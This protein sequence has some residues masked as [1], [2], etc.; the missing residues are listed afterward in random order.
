MADDLDHILNK[1]ESSDDTNYLNMA[2]HSWIRQGEFTL[3]VKALKRALTNFKKIKNTNEIFGCYINIGC[4]Y[5]LAKDYRH[6]IEY[7]TKALKY[8]L[9]HCDTYCQTLAY[10]NVGGVLSRSG[11]NVKKGI[12][13]LKHAEKLAIELQDHH[14]HFVISKELGYSYGCIGQNALATDYYKEALC[15]SEEFGSNYRLD[16]LLEFGRF[17][18]NSNNSSNAL[19]CYKEALE[20]SSAANDTKSVSLCYMNIGDLHSAQGAFE[21]ATANY[22][23]AKVIAQKIHD[24]ELIDNCMGRLMMMQAFANKD[25]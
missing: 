18:Q 23:R 2:A 5:Q 20:L 10:T 22:L 24:Q 8:A 25:K 3:A 6:S 12:E 14:R 11:Q 7:F 1:I 19:Q 17:Y 15:R 9:R 4:A 16:C 21:E 13:H